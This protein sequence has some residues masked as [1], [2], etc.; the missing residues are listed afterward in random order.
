[1]QYFPGLRHS[2]G[3]IG[4]GMSYKF[5]FKKAMEKG[6]ARLIICEDD[7][8]FPDDFNERFN[9]IGNYLAIHE[10]E[11]DVFS[12]LMSDIGDVKISKVEKHGSE[13]FVYMDK[14]ISMV[15]NVY[16]SAFFIKA[17]E[18]DETYLDIEKNTID[19]YLE[20]NTLKVITTSKF[21]VGHKEALISTIWGA[22]NSIYNKSIKDSQTRLLKKIYEFENKCDYK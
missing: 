15:F 2:M 17:V 19:R 6:I 22:E 3:W 9:C 11:W 5:L 18:W 14:M 12:G 21:L 4:C 10:G 13:I 8:E 16:C 1:M 20:N 7:T